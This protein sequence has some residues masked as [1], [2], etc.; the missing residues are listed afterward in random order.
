MGKKGK[1]EKA[2]IRQV[3]NCFNS[4]PLVNQDNSPGQ[5]KRSLRAVTAVRYNYYALLVA[6]R[7]N[8]MRVHVGEETCDGE[9]V[10]R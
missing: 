10:R 3:L 7:R 1:K 2:Y 8:W 9:G 4:I 5:P 6:I